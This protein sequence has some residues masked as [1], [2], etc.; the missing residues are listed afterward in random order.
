MARAIKV[1][2]DIEIE[3]GDKT[4]EYEVRAEVVPGSPGSWEEP[5]EGPE[6]PLKEVYY[7]DKKVRCPESSRSPRLH[8]QGFPPIVGGLP[9]TPDG[10]KCIK[11]QGTGLVKQSFRRPELDALVDDEVVLDHVPDPDEPD[12]DDDRR[13]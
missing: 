10:R 5:P 7:V 1:V 2:F 4:V 13:C 11:C 9:V 6:V 12:P 8:F 3:Y